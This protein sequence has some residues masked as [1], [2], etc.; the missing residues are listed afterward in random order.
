MFQ[1]LKKNGFSILVFLMIITPIQKASAQRL[2]PAQI[3]EFEQREDSIKPVSHKIIFAEEAF[4]RFR[5]DSLFT[6]MLVRALVLKNSFYYPFDS[7][8]SISRLYAPDSS[9][10]I[11]TWQLKKDGL[12]YFQHGAI[13]MRSNDGSL[14]LFPLMDVS[15]FTSDPLDSVRTPK[16]WIGAIYYRILLNKF[17]GKKY[18]TLLGFDDYGISSSKKWM[19]VL[20][21]ND[22][23]QPR[24]GGPYFSFGE[25]SVKRPSQ[26]RYNIEFKKEAGTTFNYDPDKNMI[27]FDELISETDQPKYKD[28]Y[29][30]DGDFQGFK[31][32]NGQWVHVPKVFDSKL[33]DGEYPKD[34][35]I[36]DENGNINENKLHEQSQLNRSKEDSTKKKK[37]G[38]L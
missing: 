8:R 19:E 20:T 12:T 24:F 34:N 17:N 32:V 15:D 22:A 37:S 16:N 38:N 35:F 1:K 27:V 7:L 10:R 25:D 29:V 30:P 2:S 11:F 4:D 6:R 9:F 26:Y 18:Y 23:G 28:T 31:W 13:Q 3:K 21:F 33:K 5:A 14:K 36:R